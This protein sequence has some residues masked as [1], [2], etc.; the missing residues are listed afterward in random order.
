MAAHF[1][2]LSLVFPAWNEEAMLGRTVAA[3]TDIGERLVSDGNV[4]NYEIV[5]VDD[6][7]TDATPK[8]IDDFAAADPHVRPVRHERNRGLGASIRS[9]FAAATGDVVLYTD[10]D[11]PFD[12]LELHK[13]L[14]LLRVYDADIVS[15]YRLDRTGEGPKRFVFSHI[16]NFLIRYSLGLRVRDVNFAGKVIRRDVLDHLDLQSEG[17]FLDA[18]LMGKAERLGFTIVQFGVDYFPR[19]RGTSTLAG[20]NVIVGM[21]RDLARWRRR[22]RQIEP[23]PGGHRRS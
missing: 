18:E 7:S 2:R 3:A 6:G 12:L 17:S 8:L 5:L 20:T 21:L 16:Y 11:L 4:A 19:T 14:R 1:N 9:G 13:A 22:L 23:L 10:A 15:M